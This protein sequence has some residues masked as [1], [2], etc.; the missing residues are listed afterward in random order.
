MKERFKSLAGAVVARAL[1]QC[2]FDQALFLLGHMRCGSTALSAILCSRPDVSGY[3]EAHIAYTG[4]GALGILAMNQRRRGAWD[5]SATSLF[6]KILH[7]RY[8]EEACSEFFTSRAIFMARA[9]VPAIRSIRHLFARLG[10]GEYATDVL[11]ADYYEER[12]SALLALWPR[13]DASRRVACTYEALTANPEAVLARISGQLNLVPA[14]RNEYALKSAA[15]GRGA[16]DPLSAAQH[17]RIVAGK[18]DS[19]AGLPLALSE[20]RIE[21]LE[22]LYRQ[23]A[24]LT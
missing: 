17:S 13:F 3:G 10:T 6:D 16:G 2:R 20:A 1:P 12:V 21:D 19:E 9:P 22:R 7:S 23:F 5:R 14:L 4:R 8:D 11:A 18:A 15:T 24:E